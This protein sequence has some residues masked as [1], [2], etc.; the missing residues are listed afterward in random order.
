VEKKRWLTWSKKILGAIPQR[1][2]VRV[3]DISR[4]G[5]LKVFSKRWLFLDIDFF[6]KKGSDDNIHGQGSSRGI[7]EKKYSIQR[8]S[9]Q[10]EKRVYF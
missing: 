9:W 2:K 3:E 10:Q 4:G 5:R 8:I 1:Q 6:N 7:L